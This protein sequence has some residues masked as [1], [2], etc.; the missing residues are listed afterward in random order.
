MSAIEVQN[1]TKAFRGTK[2]LQDISINITS[3]DFI[4]ILGASGSGKTTFL[5]LVAGLD[6]PTNGEINF[7]NSSQLSYVF[8]DPCLLPWLTVE[9]NIKLPFQLLREKPAR[10][11]DML[12]LVGLQNF[13]TFYPGQLS[14][15]MKMR[16]SLA[17]ALI[18]NP[19]I[20]LLD[21]P[22]GALDEMTRF[23]LQDE[24][25]SIWHE[26]KMTILFVTHSI[27]EAVYLSNRVFLLDK[28]KKNFVRETR[29]DL[30]A[31][32]S[33]SLKF[34]VNYMNYVTDLSKLLRGQIS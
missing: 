15:G 6:R 26:R 7:S 11:E 17:R 2:V 33:Q 29:V 25:R 8:Q 4:S 19:E 13:K 10:V 12:E 31:S 30:P 27:S 5:R 3:G 1:L 16:V 22:F 24:L 23:Q 18:T 34:Q 14:G 9:E 28:R 21:E 32:R 20:I